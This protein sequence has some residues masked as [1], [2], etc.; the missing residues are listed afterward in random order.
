MKKKNHET[1]NICYKTSLPSRKRQKT[2]TFCYEK[3]LEK[4]TSE[5]VL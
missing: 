4:V 3:L 2:A 1:V 5:F